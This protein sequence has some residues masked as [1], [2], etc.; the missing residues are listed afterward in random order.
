M[1]SA[2]FQYASNFA[3]KFKIKIH[4][5]HTLST[6]LPDKITS[7]PNLSNYFNSEYS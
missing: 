1:I 2:Y 7:F 3:F 5:Y 6:D 4:L